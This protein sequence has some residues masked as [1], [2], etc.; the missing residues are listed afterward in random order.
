MMG[1]FIW[2]V[3]LLF[4]GVF[5]GYAISGQLEMRKNKTKL[6]GSDKNND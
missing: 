3:M 2:T 4:V 1:V 5:I 6:D